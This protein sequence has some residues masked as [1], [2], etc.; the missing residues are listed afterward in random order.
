MYGPNLFVHLLYNEHSVALATEE[1][2]FLALYACMLNEYEQGRMWKETAL[3]KF[4]VRFQHLS[5]AG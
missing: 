2:P 5:E 1:G 4:K 3:S